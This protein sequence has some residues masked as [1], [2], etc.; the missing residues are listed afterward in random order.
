MKQIL[1]SMF[2]V[3]FIIGCGILDIDPE[4]D[5][6]V[7]KGDSSL[8]AKLQSETAEQTNH[9]QDDCYSRVAEKNKG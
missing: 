2:F 6:A 9:R 4:I 8:C 7:T 5:Y 1:L 3:I